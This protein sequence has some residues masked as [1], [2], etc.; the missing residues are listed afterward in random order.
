M[1][2]RELDGLLDGLCGPTA[3]AQA[4]R[5][6]E[7]DATA[8]L[9][10]YEAM[11]ERLKGRVA[12]DAL[13]PFWPEATVI[14]PAVPPAFPASPDREL[15]LAL[16]GVGSLAL[17]S[18][19]AL[20]LNALFPVVT[21]A[22]E[23]ERMTG[24]PVL[25]QIPLSPRSGLRSLQR[26]LRRRGS[27][28]LADGLRALRV[29]IALELRDAAPRVLLLTSAKRG[30]GKS[31]TGYLLAQSFVQ[32][33]RKVLLIDAD[34]ATQGPF[35]RTPKGPGLNSVLLGEVDP[36]EAIMSDETS[37][38]DVLMAPEALRDD[39]DLFAYGEERVSLSKFATGYNIV[40]LIAP[41]VGTLPDAR[42]WHGWPM[43]LVVV[44]RDAPG[45]PRSPK[46]WSCSSVAALPRRNGAALPAR[47]EAKISTGLSIGR[48][49]AGER[50]VLRR[51]T[52][53]QMSNV[54]GY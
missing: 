14:S 42:S 37:G 16:G 22:R 7:R 23:L 35:G 27:S 48:R 17:A 8:S 41:P 29:A 24:M 28:P 19:L 45:P 32:A 34:P 36:G 52:K 39:A 49:G 30:E 53:A 54:T 13:D 40:I 50:N 11:L 6:A 47:L 5:D 25:G 1:R 3:E 20:L 46:R 18:G 15:I 44:R 2:K 26:Q 10:A 43:P 31:R 38:C 33:G 51:R 12:V 9:A 21:T 4:L